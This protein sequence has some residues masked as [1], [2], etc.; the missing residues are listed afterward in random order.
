MDRYLE[1]K[2]ECDLEIKAMESSHEL[3]KLS[4]EWLKL[5]TKFKYTYHFEWLGRPI[6]Q[7]PQDVLALQEIIWDTRPDIVIETGIAHGGSLVLSAS[8]LALLDL[9]DLET[10][11]ERSVKRKV[12]GVDIDIREHNREAIQAHPL[13]SRIEM[14]EDSSTSEEL[15]NILKSRISSDDRVMVILDSNHTE[16]HVLDELRAYANFVSS[17]CYLVVFDTVIQFLDEKDSSDRPWGIGNN[18]W[19]AVQGFLR[20][21]DRFL[22][23]NHLES[24]LQLT[25]APSGFLK[26]K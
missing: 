6:I 7:L 23:N 3:N 2:T 17:G 26:R 13:S 24:K 19:T 22:V 11:V 12:F 25:V 18:P 9:V 15:I 21:D 4:N 10:G 16:S 1:F 8:I 20:E 14:F 5:A